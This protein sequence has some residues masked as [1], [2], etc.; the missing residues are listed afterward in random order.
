[1]NCKG[2]LR[3]TSPIK[4]RNLTTQLVNTRQSTDNVRV[5]DH[6]HAND[7]ID[8]DENSFIFGVDST[9][10]QYSTI[11]STQRTIK[12]IE[13]LKNLTGENATLANLSPYSKGIVTEKVKIP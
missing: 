5:I 2:I 10:Y 11:H 13:D 4:K 6:N 9:K 3:K 1:M 8:Y 7:S 12:K